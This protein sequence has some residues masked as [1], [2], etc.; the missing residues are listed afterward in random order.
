MQNKQTHIQA[1]EWFDDLYT[2][3]KNN[4][5]NIPWAKLEVNPLLQSYLESK[6]SHK[7]KALV[8]GC[9]L[10]D[11]AKALEMVG[12]EVVAI[13]ISQSALDMAQE[14]FPSETIKFEKENIFD[15]P[16]KYEKHFDFVFEA[17]TIQ[18]LPI[19]FRQKM[20]KS[21]G[22]TLKLGALLLIVAHKRDKDF[23]GPPW[24][25]TQAEIDYFKTCQLNEVSFKI[26]DEPS[27]ISATKFNVIYQKV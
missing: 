26:E 3:S 6:Q 19:E 15:M 20:M 11:D 22:N 1:T 7:G 17:F 10:G 18:S 4:Y 24:P 8:I 25:L 2:K 27:H 16:K 21:I 14:R 5:E 12:Y 23:S 9:G 13:D